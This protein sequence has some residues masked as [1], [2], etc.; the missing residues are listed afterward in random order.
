MWL[1][2]GWG[3]PTTKKQV[4][5]KYNCNRHVLCMGFFAL[6]TTCGRLKITHIS[7]SQ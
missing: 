1:A 4:K 2:K 3:I 5:V 7:K 6:S